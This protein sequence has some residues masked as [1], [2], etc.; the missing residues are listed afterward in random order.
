MRAYGDRRDLHAVWWSRGPGQI[1][2]HHRA[3]NIGVLPHFEG[4]W[5]L[6]PLAGPAACIVAAARG[7]VE[8]KLWG[9]GLRSP[10]SGARRAKG[11]SRGVM[12]TSVAPTARRREARALAF[13]GPDETALAVK[14]RGLSRVVLVE[15]R[16]LALHQA[17]LARCRVLVAGDTGLG[18]LAALVG[19]PVV[20][21]AGPTPVREC[22]PWG[23]QHTVVESGHAMSC[24]PCFGT[25]L[26]GHC[27]FGR[28]CMT[29][30][31]AADVLEP[32]LARLERPSLSGPKAI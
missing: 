21:A 5:A 26:W 31:A 27:P 14:F 17:L 30:I 9:G 10:A 1:G 8:V 11:A 13:I 16:D 22:G 12:R 2:D 3:I 24:R 19:V 20:T 6:R 28:R 32:V 7:A 18:H 23:D 15:G 4:I 29:T 25:V